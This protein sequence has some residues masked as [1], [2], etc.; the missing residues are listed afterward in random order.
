LDDYLLRA[1]DEDVL[2]A[3]ASGRAPDETRRETMRGTVVSWDAPTITLP[4]AQVAEGYR[5]IDERR[6]IKTLLRP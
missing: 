2:R 1:F 3:L 4:L 6:T 5:A